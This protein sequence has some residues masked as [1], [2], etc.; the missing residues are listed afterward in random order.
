MPFAAN[1]RI[2]IATIGL[3]GMGT[4]DTRNAL[5]L[6]GT[7]L[8]A[9]SDIYDGR[10]RRGRER[11][12]D[13]LFTTRDYREILDRS[14]VD[15]VIVATPD[16]WHARI[17]REA[18]AA[19]KDVYCQKP[20]VQKIEEGKPVIEAERASGRILQIGSQYVSSL[21]YAKAREL[22]KA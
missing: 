14:D 7:E 9:V 20:M 6:P 4:G 18:L 19:G 15:A 5:S 1:D 11:F 13:S 3:G 17:T 22:L 16:H 2:R 8:V 10:L 12:G 21:V